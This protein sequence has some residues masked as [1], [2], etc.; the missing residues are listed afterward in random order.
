MHL[1]IPPQRTAEG[2]TVVLTGELDHEAAP[3]LR[4]QLD[5]L[6]AEGPRELLLDLTTATFIDSTMLG[7]F[8]YAARR[9]QELG[10]S[11]VVLCPDPG[12]RRIF[13]LVG[14]DQLFAVR[15]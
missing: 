11:L 14:L 9:L 1:E 5:A 13:Q 4:R 2:A 12:M 6:I 7:V 8:V 15:G 3:E 10:A